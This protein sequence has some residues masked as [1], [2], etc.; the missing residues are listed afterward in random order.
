MTDPI[1]QKPSNHVDDVLQGYLDQLLLTATE[2]LTVVDTQTPEA[3][4]SAVTKKLINTDAVIESSTPERVASSVIQQQK[5][6]IDASV[7]SVIAV[8]KTP[9]AEPD[10]T[11]LSRTLTVPLQRV[12]LPDA[13]DA[14]PQVDPEPEPLYDDITEPAL[15]L[16]GD[17]QQSELTAK[18]LD[19][20]SS[21][22]V[23]CLIFKVA[24]LKLAIPLS[25][26]GGVHNASDKITPL[27][28]QADWSVGVWQSDAQKLTIVDSAQLIMPERG[29]RL[30][31]QG[32]GFVIQL[33]RSHWALACE[34]ICDTTT[35]VYDSIKWRGDN[36]KRPWLAGTVIDEMCALIDVPN[37]MDMLE[38]NTRPA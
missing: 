21:Q 9:F 12:A 2:T 4:G 24:G 10:P 23:E 15:Q 32:F 38:D 18:S 17:T 26:L 30:N 14:F 5:T 36:S 34:E 1:K 25:L 33:D 7:N 28:G 37:L 6:A 11:R 27:F 16:E 22:G 8:D 35:L 3:S 31:D 13:V 19:W 20:R 29:I